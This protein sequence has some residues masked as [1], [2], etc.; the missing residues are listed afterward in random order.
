MSK[1][2]KELSNLI[3]KH[4]REDASNTPDFILAKFLTECLYAWNGAT[5]KRENWHGRPE[6][7]GIECF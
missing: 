5:Q 7:K 6:I 1:F 3:N 4:S 2:E